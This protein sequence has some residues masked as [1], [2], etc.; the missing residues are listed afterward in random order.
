MTMAKHSISTRLMVLSGLF[1]ALIAVGAFIRIPV[2]LIPFTLQL[3]FVTMA[4]F[5]LGAR[6]GALSAGLY[7]VLGL[8]GL[9]IFTE[10]GGFGYI[11]KPTFGYIVGFV[12]S[13]YIIGRMTEGVARPSFWRLLAAALVGVAVSYTM[14][15]VYCYLVSNWVLGITT[16]AWQIFFYGCVLELPG[17]V[18]LSV[19]AALV[20]VRILP[21]VA[22]MHDGKGKKC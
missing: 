15:M 14:G 3:F 10:G 12:L 11:F 13:A 4:G 8:I 16:S 6:G 21:A 1:T 18:A 9:P 5:V 7:M 17:D 19:V 2:P 22:Y 20:G